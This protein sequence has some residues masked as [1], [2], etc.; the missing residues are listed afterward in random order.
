MALFLDLFLDWREVSVAGPVMRLDVGSSGWSNGW[1]I[2][3]GVVVMALVIFEL[4]LLAAGQNA[5]GRA[6]AGLVAALGTAVLGFTIAAFAATSVDVTTPMAAVRIG[7]RQ[8]PA[9]A[10][11]VLATAV[12]VGGF[13]ELTGA[14]SVASSREHSEPDGRRATGAT[15]P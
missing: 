2:A 1:G 6:R 5:V 9:F 8:W 15:H 7:D 14:S 10:G 13:L 4:P 12:A 3:A 11:L